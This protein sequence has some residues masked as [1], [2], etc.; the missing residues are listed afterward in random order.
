VVSGSNSSSLRAA[1]SADYE[2]LAKRLAICLGSAD[3]AREALHEAFL[4]AERAT[5][6]ATVR[7]PADYLFRTAINVA[8]D[9]RKRDKHLLSADEIAA[10]TEIPDERP[11]P[12]AVVADRLELKEFSKALAELP[13]RRRNVFIAAHLEQVSHQDIADRF[14]IN[15]RT[16]AF[17]LQHAM[18]HLGQRLGR[19]ITRR[20]GPQAKAESRE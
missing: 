4:R 3:L 14:G 9:R 18:E 5:D 11:D 15:A 19:K 6:D 1:L 20:F 8:K 13:D 17:D 10:I 7:S 12:F 2:G 16:V